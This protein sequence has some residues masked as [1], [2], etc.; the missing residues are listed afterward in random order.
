M[1]KETYCIYKNHNI[2]RM[3]FNWL[4]RLEIAEIKL[5]K[6]NH[7]QN[8]FDGIGHF[9]NMSYL[10]RVSIITYTVLHGY[11]EQ[12][13]PAANGSLYRKC[14]LLSSSHSILRNAISIDPISRECYILLKMGKWNLSKIPRS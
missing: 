4:I 12:L 7:I 8:L 10:F 9:K 6:R 5:V 13:C 14:L 1:N 3:F 2:W 11:Q